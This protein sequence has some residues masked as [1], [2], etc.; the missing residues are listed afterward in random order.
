M[1]KHTQTI[2][3][4]LPLPTNCLNVFHHFVGLALKGLNSDLPQPISTYKG[5][6]YKKGNNLT[7][8]SEVIYHISVQLTFPKMGISTDPYVS[9]A[10]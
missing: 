5:Y 9:A 1:V 6:A 3:D 8:N 7:E 2:A 4:E 10:Q